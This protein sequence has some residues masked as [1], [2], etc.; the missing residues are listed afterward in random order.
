MSGALTTTQSPTN[1][2]ILPLGTNSVVITVADASGNKS[3]S[4]NTVVV[5]DQ[6]PPQILSQPQSLTN[7]INTTATFSVA[8]SACTLL[9]FQWY[10][11]N[12]LTIFTNTT[13]T[14]SNLAVSAAGNY[15]A[16]ANAGGGSSTSLVATLTVNLYP[17]AISA[18]AFNF[19][20]GFNLNLSGSPGYT[21]ILEA[22]TNLLS[23]GNWLP[24]ATNTL[25]TNGVW[26]FTDSTATNFPFQ[27]YRLKFAP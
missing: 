9:T 3:Y 22:T 4:T 15:F 16:V 20:G 26:S 1:S 19:N 10:S 23:S 13:L 2:F 27:F 6:T 25:G 17:P 12:S 11:N 5:L 24:L 21:Y 14:L 18:A 8:A 7:F